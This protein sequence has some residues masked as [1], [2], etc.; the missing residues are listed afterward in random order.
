[1]DSPRILVIR[2]SAIGDC[3][4]TAWAVTSIRQKLPSARI[5]WAVEPRCS[6]VIDTM[7]L[8][9]EKL[10]YD[11]P[12]WKRTRSLSQ[13]IREQYRFFVNLRKREYDWG[14]DFQGHSKTAICLR[15]ARPRKRLMVRATDEFAKRLNPYL[16]TLRAPV[17]TVE[18]NQSAL[19]EFGEFK[20][21]LK[22]IMPR[23]DRMEVQLPDG[24]YVVI[25]VGAGQ[26][27]KT[28]SIDRWTLAAEQLLQANVPVVFVG[29]PEG[30]MPLGKFDF[31]YVGKTNL[32]TTIEIVARSGLVFCG[33][34]GVGHLAAAYGVP[35]VSIF[36]PTDPAVFRPY[37]SRS[38]VLRRGMACNNI[39][40][41]EGLEAVFKRLGVV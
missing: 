22:P 30:P 31:D 7:Q 29:G 34:T 10:E 8:V 26:S 2:F 5:D 6:A 35:G 19:S 27:D 37:S 40:V 13:K 18:L 15:L 12:R 1:M 23:K 16:P 28:W 3:V 39:S 14:I 41:E 36:G 25:A 33:D 11:R 32:E 17:H 38:T 21:S 9:N 24:R 20:M 4:M